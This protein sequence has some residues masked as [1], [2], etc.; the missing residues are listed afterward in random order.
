MIEAARYAIYFIPSAESG[1]YRF[2]RAA[3]GYDCYTGE[4]V[5]FPADL[6]TE[7]VDWKKVTVEPRRYGFHATLKAPFHLASSCSEG[8][9]A[10]A[11]AN[12]AEL[13]HRVIR[14]EP[15]I[16]ALG[17]FIA[18]VP[19]EPSAV[20][21]ALADQCATIFD[22]FRAPMTAQERAR[23][24]ASRLSASQSQNLDRWGYPYV[25]DDFRFH[26]TLTGPV[27]PAVRD[28]VLAGL[29]RSFAAMCEEREIAVDRLA[30]VKQAHGR[31][32]FRV[33]CQADL[34]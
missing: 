2:G 26:M 7:T 21:N 32:R 17:N 9:L 34:D 30:L 19:R 28:E 3:L 29:R 24:A 8:Q 23:R 10:S 20:L 25:F 18:L 22:A 14:T 33:I 11:V 5:P 1:L 6:G 12:F 4:E 13:G 31:A 15:D 16:R 27:P